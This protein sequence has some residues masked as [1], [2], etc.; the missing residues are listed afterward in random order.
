MRSFLP[1]KMDEGVTVKADSM[2]PQIESP[3]ITAG[4]VAL[5]LPQLNPCVSDHAFGLGMSNV[6][7]KSLAFQKEN[8]L[9]IQSYFE[10]VNRA[11]QPFE[12]HIPHVDQRHSRA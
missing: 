12:M 9:V 10:N 5:S 3:P 11:V 6:G 8:S 1:Q 7:E 2:I 4:F